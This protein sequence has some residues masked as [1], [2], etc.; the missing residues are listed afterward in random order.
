MHVDL[1]MCVLVESI[2]RINCMY[3]HRLQDEI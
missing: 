1:E 2:K 3:T